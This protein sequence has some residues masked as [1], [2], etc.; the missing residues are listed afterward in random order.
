MTLIA[1]GSVFAPAGVAAAQASPSSEDDRAL[2]LLSFAPR[3]SWQAP[4][5]RPR[6]WTRRR[7]LE[8]VTLGWVFG[9]VWFTAT[10]G[11][12]LTL[13]GKA[14]GASKFQFGLMAALPFL[15]SLV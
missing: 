7:S 9:A 15:A 4:W 8:M 6:F 2:P 12:P 13:M 10:S 11:A 3:L 14:L 1:D 5:T